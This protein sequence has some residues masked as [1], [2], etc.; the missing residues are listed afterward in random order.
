[1]RTAAA[2]TTGRRVRRAA[3]I[4]GSVTCGFPYLVVR[5]NDPGV[6]LEDDGESS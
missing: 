6:I 1:M 4:Q 2:M 5:T 3:G